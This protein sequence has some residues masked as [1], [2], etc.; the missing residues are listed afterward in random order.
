MCVPKHAPLHL[1]HFR[2]RITFIF[3]SMHHW[4]ELWLFSCFWEMRGL[5]SSGIFLIM[6]N[7]SRPEEQG[8]TRRMPASVIEENLDFSVLT[9]HKLPFK[10]YLLTLRSQHYHAAI[11]WWPHAEH[12]HT[13][14]KMQTLPCLFVWLPNQATAMG[15]RRVISG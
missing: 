13:E 4:L 2:S 6:I 11:H 9:S 10:N 1:P 3:P 8:Y 5:A 12:P 14:K 15:T 7:K